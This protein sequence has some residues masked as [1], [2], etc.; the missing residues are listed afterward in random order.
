MRKLFLAVI[1]ILSCT[2]LVACDEDK[3]LEQSSA[4][5]TQTI[6]EA[7]VESTMELTYSDNATK[8]EGTS[9]I[10]GSWENYM[11]SENSKNK[12]TELM[13]GKVYKTNDTFDIN[14]FGFTENE[15]KFKEHLYKG[16]KYAFYDRNADGTNLINNTRAKVEVESITF[17]DDRFTIVLKYY[18]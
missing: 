4:T 8:A 16:V 7:T 12:V 9:T 18:N 11:L 1:T 10:Q 14:Q 13:T 6:T 5:A 15:V 2:V 3:T 17:S